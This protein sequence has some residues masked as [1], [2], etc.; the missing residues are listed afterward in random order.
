MPPLILLFSSWLSW[1]LHTFLQLD[2]SCCLKSRLLLY[3]YTGTDRYIVTIVSTPVGTPVIG[4]TSTF[5]YPILSSVTLTCMVEPS[6]STNI[7]YQWN[8][9]GCYVNNHNERRCFPVNQ[10]TQNVTEDDLHARDAG[11]VTCSATIDGVEYHSDPFTLRISG[12]LIY[13]CTT[14]Q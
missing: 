11:T 2:C 10:T 4:S 14:I 13:M 7:T 6:A 8:T 3:P 9:T 12:T 5:D 1:R